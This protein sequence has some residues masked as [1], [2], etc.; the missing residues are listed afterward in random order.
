[1]KGFRI[2]FRVSVAVV[3]V[4]VAITF[5]VVTVAEPVQ[6]GAVN[7][8]EQGDHRNDEHHKGVFDGIRGAVYED[9][10][11]VSPAWNPLDKTPLP[12]N[13]E[14]LLPP[15]VAV[16]FWGMTD[17]EATQQTA[18]LNSVS[19]SKVDSRA[20]RFD[21]G[22][23]EVQLVSRDEMSS[24]INS[25]GDVQIER[26]EVVGHTD[27]QALSENTRL[28]YR[29]NIGLSEARAKRVASLLQ[30]RLKLDATK[31]NYRGE[32]DQYPIAENITKDGRAKN[33]RVEVNVW[34]QKTVEPVKSTGFNR[35]QVCSTQPLCRYYTEH[36]TEQLV[37]QHS[38]QFYVDQCGLEPAQIEVITPTIE[39]V[40]YATELEPIR[41]YSGSYQISSSYLEYLRSLIETLSTEYQVHFKFSGHTDSEPL[42]NPENIQQHKD[43]Q[44]LSEQRAQEVM[45]Y[46]VNKL[47]FDANYATAVGYG[48]EQPIADNLLEIDK[49]KNRRV[50]ISILTEQPVNK[51]HYEKGHVQ[52]INTPVKPVNPMQLSP[53]RITVDGQ[54]IDNNSNWHTADE[55]RCTDVALDAIDLQLTADNLSVKPA[56]AV[57]AT[58]SSISITDQ[59]DTEIIENYV[60]FS[61]YSNYLDFIGRA[62]IRLFRKS[63]RLSSTPLAVLP[64]NTN[65]QRGWQLDAEL[66]AKNTTLSEGVLQSDVPLEILYVLRVYD[67]KGKRY[68]ETIPSSLWLNNG[69]DAHVSEQKWQLE[70]DAVGRD[71]APEFGENM[72][73][74]QRIKISG[75]TITVNGKAV[76]AG[77]TPYIMGLP[78]A[79]DESE[80]F[81]VQQIIPEGYHRIEVALLDKKGNGEIWYRELEL[82]RDDWFFVGMA[83]MTLGLRDTNGPASEVTQNSQ[84][85]D[86]SIADGR[87]AFFTHGKTQS[88]LE[89]TASA[90]TREG[91]IRDLF[92]NF[93]NKDPTVLFRRLDQDL[94]Y[95]TFG[96]DSTIEEGAPTQ[97]KFYVQ[98]KRDNDKILWGNFD[99]SISE[100]ELARIDRGLYGLQL[101]YISEELTRGG[102]ERFE[103]ELFAA[104]P[105]TIGAREE[106]RGTG[107][108]LYFLR[109]QDITTGSDNLYIETRDAQTARVIDRVRLTE[110]RDY[111]IDY[112]QGRVFLERPLSSSSSDGQLITADSLGGNENYLVVTYEY[113]PGFEELDDLA[114]GG[115]VSTHINDSI[116]LGV[117][118]LEQE[119]L[120]NDQS[121]IGIDARYENQ[122]GT[123]LKV[124]V[125]QTEGLAVDQLQSFDGGFAFTEQEQSVDPNIKA[126]AARIELAQQFTHGL[127][128]NAFAQLREKGY[129]ASGQLTDTETIDSGLNIRLPLGKKIQLQANL[130]ERDEAQGQQERVADLQLGY[131]LNKAWHLEGAVRYDSIEN[132]DPRQQVQQDFGSRTEL[133]VAIEF[134]SKDVWAAY[135][136]GQYTV[137]S[138]STRDKND[139]IGI[140]GRYQIGEKLRLDAEVSSGTTGLGAQLGTDYQVSERTNLYFTLANDNQRA[141]SG[142]RTLNGNATAGFKSRMTEKLSIYGEERYAYGDQPTG[143][144]HAYGLDYSLND[145]WTFGGSAEV[146]TLRNE[147]RSEIDRLALSFLTGFSAETIN[148]IGEVEYRSDQTSASDRVTWLSR[149][150]LNYQKSDDW[151]VLFELD[152]S[153]SKSS[154]GEFF[155]GDFTEAAL[156]YAY[157]PV[158]ND[159]LNTLFKYTYFFNKPAPEQ[160]STNNANSDF[161]QRSH[162]FAVDATYDLNQRWSMGAKYAYKLGELALDRVNPQYFSSDTQLVVLR[163]D[164]HLVNSWDFLIEARALDAITAQDTR[165]GFLTG[166]YKHVN[167]NVKLGVG[168]N[169]T[170]FSDDLT[171]LSFDSQGLFINI[172]GKM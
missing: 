101:E 82:K 19:E 15:D 69:L 8:Y 169:F 40:E 83:D 84:Y 26:I 126:G 5:S 16:T 163:A 139:R 119:Q 44:G 17:T 111:E 109:H 171:D 103:L 43:N 12:N 45:D 9:A 95:P 107:G 34:Y 115:R 47:D 52:P 59:P 4:V 166:L 127:A 14:Q 165:S 60:L 91:P 141:T 121:L 76:P 39:L 50:D 87:L 25:L 13:S 140:G 129:S 154:Q 49:A 125:A 157:R 27:N 148:Y 128:V 145:H 134:Q 61:A 57:S 3:R 137:K 72:L 114:L 112:L 33:R 158:N 37:D 7:L 74:R 160:Q 86:K 23:S 131:K 123:R 81:V 30:K 151:R 104:E 79:Q 89:I 18:S 58:P 55:Q 118:A 136:F 64:L 162:V 156:G 71:R 88:G 167:P 22:E 92:S 6:R 168:Y 31:V 142:I 105:G 2:M 73:A 153:S 155:D 77:Y 102:K 99:A 41:F 66:F 94:Y 120:G 133:G 36:T 143:L 24:L 51:V 164:L 32:G 46:V 10:D 130:D 172:I 35:T 53:F 146:G 98:V 110:S 116:E 96:D 21:S 144:T 90:D 78:I 132:T 152:W 117:T 62:E 85:D 150:N 11:T 170:D 80:N 63:Q 54:P 28:R 147:D 106:F 56:L 38:D 42:K 75:G 1:M 48:S 122:S 135:G 67:H 159:R 124:E 70:Q 65:M 138:E 113:T 93:T 108:S 161:I 149:H 100:S 97:G 68:D 29:D 20:I